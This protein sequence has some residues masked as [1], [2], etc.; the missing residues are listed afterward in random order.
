MFECSSVSHILHF[1]S[2]CPSFIERFAATVVEHCNLQQSFWA[3]HWLSPPA[4]DE[5]VHLAH[6]HWL[7]PS[8]LGLGIK[9]I[10]N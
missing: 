2:I 4:V 10:A 5:Q 7:Q 3:Q 6:L 8:L 1:I 9:Y